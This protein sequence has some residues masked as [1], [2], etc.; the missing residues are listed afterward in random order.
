MIKTTTVWYLIQMFVSCNV[1]CNVSK[2][3]EIKTNSFEDCVKA[4]QIVT[5]GPY[6][7]YC[8]PRI[9]QVAEPPPKEDRSEGK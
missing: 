3:D 1:G 2:I 8:W 5:A 9:T 6:Q 7:A 4:R